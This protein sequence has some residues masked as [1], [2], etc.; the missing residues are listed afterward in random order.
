MGFL[1]LYITPPPYPLLYACLSGQSG[2][3]DCLFLTSFFHSPLRSAIAAV[4]NKPMAR[5]NS[6]LSISNTFATPISPPAANPHKYG[7]PIP[8]ASAPNAI[9]LAISVP[10]CMPPSSMISVSSPTASRM[11]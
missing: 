10:R 1:K 11:L 3:L 9:A 5:P 4:P 6:S 8:T 7:M 2:T